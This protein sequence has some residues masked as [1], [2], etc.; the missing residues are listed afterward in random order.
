MQYVGLFLVF[1][2]GVLTGVEVYRIRYLVTK[3]AN[4]ILAEKLAVAEKTIEL[5]HEKNLQITLGRIRQR[6]QERVEQE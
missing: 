6:L 4:R 3:E 1:L 2:G 5:M